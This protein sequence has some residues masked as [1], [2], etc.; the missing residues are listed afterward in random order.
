MVGVANSA[1]E[2]GLSSS[3]DVSSLTDADV[4][5]KQRDASLAGRSGCILWWRWHVDCW[6]LPS[7]RWRPVKTAVVTDIVRVDAEQRRRRARVGTERIVTCVVQMHRH[8]SARFVVVDRPRT[9]TLRD[10]TICLFVYTRHYFI[11]TFLFLHICSATVLS[12]LITV[13]L[14]ITSAKTLGYGA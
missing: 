5:D 4:H 13:I 1:V 2:A 8:V 12:A 10:A 6:S 11:S 9:L 3:I 7:Q 14:S